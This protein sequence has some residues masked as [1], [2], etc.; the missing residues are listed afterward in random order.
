MSEHL[1]HIHL[2]F[3][4][5][6]RLHTRE[7]I[8]KYITDEMIYHEIKIFKLNTAKLT[9]VENEQTYYR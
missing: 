7:G 6:E 9:L 4:P 5:L 8:S 3:S 1:Q 2:G